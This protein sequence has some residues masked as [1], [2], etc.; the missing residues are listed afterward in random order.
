MLTNTLLIFTSQVRVLL[1][2][3][4]LVEERVLDFVCGDPFEAEFKF[5]QHAIHLSP[6]IN[7]TGDALVVHWLS[8]HRRAE[9]L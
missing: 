4:E 8:N 7:S 9:T 6:S 5:L 2:M 1:F 3:L